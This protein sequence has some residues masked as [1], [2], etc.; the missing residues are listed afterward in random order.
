[1][2]LW[3]LLTLL[4][5]PDA[6]TQSALT[7]SPPT[8]SAYTPDQFHLSCPECLPIFSWEGY[9]YPSYDGGASRPFSS[10]ANGM[11]DHHIAFYGAAGTCRLEA[12]ELVVVEASGRPFHLEE[13]HVGAVSRPQACVGVGM[14]V[15]QQ[16]VASPFVW[17][18]E[19]LNQSIASLAVGISFE[20]EAKGTWN[21]L[22]TSFFVIEVGA[23]ANHLDSSSLAF[24]DYGDLTPS[25]NQIQ[26]WNRSSRNSIRRLT[27]HCLS[28][29]LQPWQRRAV[30][31]AFSERSATTS[32]CL[33][34]LYPFRSR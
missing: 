16:P 11:V 30:R 20:V 19:M 21:R 23:I 4:S 17:V 12:K 3:L 27:N 22:E 15:E 31:P 13:E 7:P 5:A 26:S 10:E 18:E 24:V 2:L 6:P 33:P 8:Y 14:H 28:S 29:T 1:M 34:S 32:S 25:L 9:C